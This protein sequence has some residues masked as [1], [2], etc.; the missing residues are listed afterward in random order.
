MIY[1]LMSEYF[2]LRDR[3]R[4]IKKLRAFY[5]DQPVEKYRQV[6]FLSRRIGRLARKK[7]SIILKVRGVVNKKLTG[8]NNV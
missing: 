1:N 2:E 4:K 8:E 5:F 3:C 6:E 7:V